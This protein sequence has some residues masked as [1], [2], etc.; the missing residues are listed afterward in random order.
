M[1]PHSSPLGEESRTWVSD[2]NWAYIM[3]LK[4]TRILL[5]RKL[6]YV[7]LGLDQKVLTFVFNDVEFNILHMFRQL[8]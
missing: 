3:Y 6:I 1:S 2:G 4:S 5:D 8:V 7:L